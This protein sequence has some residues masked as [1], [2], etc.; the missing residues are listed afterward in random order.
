MQVGS[1]QAAPAVAWNG[2]N[3]LVA[4]TGAICTVTNEGNARLCTGAPRI[5]V[6]FVGIDFTRMLKLALPEDLA[7][8]TRWRQAMRE[9]P[10]AKAGMPTR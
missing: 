4:D 2:A 3:F 5:H 7:N 8:V 10:A 6:A 9:R 1:D